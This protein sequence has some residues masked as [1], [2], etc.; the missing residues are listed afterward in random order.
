MAS[1]ARVR[2]VSPVTT[3]GCRTQRVPT[4]PLGTEGAR[5]YAARQGRRAGAIATAVRVPSGRS[6]YRTVCSKTQPPT[7]CRAESPT[8]RTVSAAKG[9]RLADCR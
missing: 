7:V 1:P 6:G 9:R 5:G 4:G 3:V 8:D 2:R